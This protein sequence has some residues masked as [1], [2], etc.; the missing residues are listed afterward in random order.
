[1]IKQLTIKNLAILDDITIDF[2]DGLNIFTGETGAGKS[3]II[4]ALSLVFGA[5]AN[6][7]MIRH[8]AEQAKIEALLFLSKEHAAKVYE[9]TEIDVSNECIIQRVLYTNGRSTAKI[10]GNLI[11][12]STLSKI[13][14]FLIDIHSQHESQFLLK[15][16][17]HLPLLD[18]YIQSFDPHFLNPYQEEYAKLKHL[19]EEQTN[20]MTKF[21]SIQDM[22]YLQYQLNELKDVLTDEQELA[23]QEEYKNLQ[24]VE[25]NAAIIDE[26]LFHLDG[27]QQA[28]DQLYYALKSLSKMADNQQS[29]SYYQR[30]ESD[31]LDIKDFV[32]TFKKTFDVSQYDE[33]K[34]NELQEQ[35]TKMNR[36]KR[37]YN[38]SHLYQLKL[39]IAEKIQLSE[40]F[41]E[42]M[43]DL[44]EK[45]Q[46]QRKQC[47]RLAKQITEIRKKYALQ[48]ENEIQCEL[49]DL[50]LEDAKFSIRFENANILTIHGNDAVAFYLSA[51]KGE[52]PMPLVK[53]ASGGEISRMMLGIKT[54]FCRVAKLSTIIFDEI[55]TGVSGKVAMAMGRKMKEIAKTSQVLAVT[56]LPQVACFSKNHLY[57]S[58]TIVD[59]RTQTK[60]ERLTQSRKIEEIA[61]LLSGKEITENSILLAKDLIFTNQ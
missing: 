35:I 14:E 25:K 61:R 3:I 9:C 45:I 17:Q 4:D 47:E 27:S 2:D 42:K 16:E 1:M 54:V 36:L 24:L 43:E 57:I 55:D 23:L 44:D 22:D 15:Q 21:Q 11:P 41:K 8:G 6:L 39:D 56:H 46:Q 18:Q 7:D 20:L 49:K 31:Y 40:S 28:L 58:K 33:S 37:K 12:I 29:Q 5:R 38:V 53:V 52:I 60:V 10:N 59:E 34:M 19:M 30:L 13:A 51:N 26:V 50:Y 48:L 32:E